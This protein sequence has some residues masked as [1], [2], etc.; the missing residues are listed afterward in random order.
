MRYCP[1]N[2]SG[3]FIFHPEEK[4]VCDFFL[5]AALHNGKLKECYTDFCFGQPYPF[6]LLSPPAAGV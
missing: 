6:V 1:S 5:K 3:S 2:L 4:I